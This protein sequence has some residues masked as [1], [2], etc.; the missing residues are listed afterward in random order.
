MKPSTETWVLTRLIDD[1]DP[2]WDE[3]ATVVGTPEQIHAMFDLSKGV[4]FGW[5]LLKGKQATRWIAQSLREEVRYQH[6]KR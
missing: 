3:C 4:P 1:S 2:L 6:A 5:R